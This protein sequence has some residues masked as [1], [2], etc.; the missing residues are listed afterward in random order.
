MNRTMDTTVEAPPAAP[1][2]IGDDVGVEDVL[3]GEAAV[4]RAARESLEGRARG[5]GRI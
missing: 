2:P 1:P 5:V 3:P 4:A